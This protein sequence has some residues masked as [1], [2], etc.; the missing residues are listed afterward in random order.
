MDGIERAQLEW[1]QP[2]SEIEDALVDAQQIEMSQRPAAGF[3][4]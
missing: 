4:R 3:P 2:T 1:Q